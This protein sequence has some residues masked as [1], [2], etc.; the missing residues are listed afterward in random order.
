MG[1][2]FVAHM[3]GH[4]ADFVEAG[5]AGVR[6][7]WGLGRLAQLA[8]SDIVLAARPYL[9][10]LFEATHES[11]DISARQGSEVSFLDRIVSDQELRAVPIAN[12]PRRLHAMA[13]GKAL[14]SSMSDAQVERLRQVAGADAPHHHHPARPAGRPGA[15]ARQRL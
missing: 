15:G 2:Q 13:N 4:K 9:E 10:A 12:K 7:G 6:L 14:L 11:V 3:H 8:Q 1:V 5:D